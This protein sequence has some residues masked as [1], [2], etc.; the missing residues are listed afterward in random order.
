ML[1]NLC[2]DLLMAIL[3]S[4][5]CI[6]AGAALERSSGRRGGRPGSFV[7]NSLYAPLALAIQAVAM[8]AAAGLTTLAVGATTG[9]LISLPS[10]GWGVL[11]GAALYIV[12]MDLG[13]YLFHRAQHAI[14]QLWALHS[15]HHSDA[16]VNVSTTVRQHWLDY[17]LKSATIYLII[18]LLFRT[19]VAVVSIYTA[20]SFYHYFVHTDV[21]VGFGRLSW[22]LNA[23]AYHRLH[24]SRL[25]QHFET[26]YAAL[27][28]IFDLISG[29][30][31]QPCRGERPPTGLDTG[32]EPTTLLDAI[33]WPVRSARIS[34]TAP[35]GATE[36]PSGNL[37][38]RRL[39]P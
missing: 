18:G 39:Q 32:A 4:G 24:H 31:L 33:L 21:D 34:A 10:R 20:M 17:F 7:F 15:L 6:A 1:R 23:P 19:N 12:V 2:F 8:P 13:E 36:A 14:P 16:S 9:G 22:A 25:P 3:V 27:F 28:P 37:V 29:R 5:A 30:Y 26:N 35:V 38:L 11:G